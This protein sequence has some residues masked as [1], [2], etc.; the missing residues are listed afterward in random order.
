MRIAFFPLLLVFLCAPG[1]V[2]CNP[3]KSAQKRERL[4]QLQAVTN[5]YRKLMRW[6]HYDQAAQY[7]KAREVPIEPPDLKDMARYKLTNFTVADELVADSQVEAKVTAYI[8]FYNVDTGV[9]ASV[10]D[11]Q[12]WWYDDTSNR[13]YLGTPMVRFS[14]YE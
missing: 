9:A 14:D 4:T 11:I 13:W 12:Y 1:L 6:G 2:A 3:I 10:R 7:I 8:E 5:T